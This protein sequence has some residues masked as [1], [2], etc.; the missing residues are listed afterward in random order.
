M[1]DRPAA[2]RRAAA[3]AAVGDPGRPGHRGAS[4]GAA[5]GGGRAGRGGGGVPGG[6]ARGRE[7]VA[8]G[9]AAEA[10]WADGRGEVLVDSA[11][12]ASLATIEFAPPDELT[13]AQG[14]V[15]L[16]ESVRKEHKVA[17]L[18]GAAIDGHA[19]VEERGEQGR[20][21]RRWNGR[22]RPALLMDLRRPRP[23]GAGH[24][25][26]AFAAGWDEVGNELLVWQRG[27]GLWDPA[28]DR[29]RL[30]A[31]VLGAVAGL[32]G[33]GLVAGGA[34]AANRWGPPFLVVV[35]V[36][37]LLAGAGLAALV[38]S[39]SCGCGRRPG[40]G[41][42]CGWSRSGASSPG[43]RPITPTRPPSA[44]SSGSTP[45]G[46]WRWGRSTAGRGR[47]RRP[48]WRPIRRPPA[49][50]TSP[51][52]WRR[53]RPPRSSRRRAGAA[54]VAAGSGAAPAGWRRVLV[55]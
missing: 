4:A 3:G 45:P 38:R 23:G 17:W 46:R 31:M 21:V 30:M 18:I 10:A 13:A 51:R 14:G 12:L 43:P 35:A 49:T 16:A 48:A 26:P 36:G 42:G 20:L 44:G 9:G 39:W 28:G 52:R 55:S 29:R 8:A 24:V 37:A 41:C 15:L 50:P 25:R 11:G 32:V 53:P 54:A 22:G 33:L 27:S 34:A 19:D 2:G 40:R 7:R 47:W 6:A 1:Q 5:G